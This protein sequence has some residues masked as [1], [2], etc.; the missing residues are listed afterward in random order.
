MLN[1]TLINK[2]SRWALIPALSLG[3]IA[4][5]DD[6]EPKAGGAEEA[7]A[8][9]GGGAGEGGSG[10]S[11]GDAGGGGEGG[12]I[13]GV[14]GMN[15]GAMGDVAGVEQGG[16]MGGTPATCLGTDT[17]GLL[18]TPAPLELAG[19]GMK[20]APQL[21][22][23][24]ESGY[25]LAWLGEGEQGSNYLH[26]QRLD[27]E[28]APLGEATVLG[29]AKGGQYRLHRTSVG[30]VALWINQRSELI[31]NE[32]VYLQTFSFDGTPRA[33][34][35]MVSGTFGVNYLASAWEDA[36]GG[37][38]LTGGSDGLQ[39]R[40]FSEQA[41]AE[42][43]TSLSA[44]QVRAPTLVFGGASF[45]ALWSTRNA[46]G[47]ISLH[48]QALDEGGAQVGNQ[49]TWE[50]TR[51]QGAAKLVYGNGTYAM[52]W[53]APDPSV[54]GGQ[55]RYLINLRLIDEAGAELGLFTL[56]EG[57][58]SMQ[59]SDLSWLSPSVFMVTWHSLNEGS[60]SLGL[61][62]VNAQGQ[63]LS[64]IVY[65]AT[66]GALLA[67]GKV[68]GTTSKAR[69]VMTIDSSPDATG[70]FS[71]ETRVSLTSVGPCE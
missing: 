22:E 56:S 5:D 19:A 36:F 3:F 30:V 63:V 18:S 2:A 17:Y 47:A 68:I 35:I 6:P 51:A 70:L 16:E 66:D 67:E 64:P 38:M 9:V 25:Q 1:V 37:L 46:E 59:L 49:R 52:A 58:A 71:T 50:D 39:V 55:G 27:A 48:F 13:G 32:S 24:P 40:A 4:C 34:P 60:Y 7:G 20:S 54:L 11:S 45:A 62:R 57:E 31:T 14:S 41:V 23:R 33:E 21:V 26:L 69:L 8:V 43:V 42:E 15:A 12:G 28:G 44:E 61:S 65:Q 29:R 10:G 53:A